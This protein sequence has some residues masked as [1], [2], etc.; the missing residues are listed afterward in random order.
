MN[1]ATDA[2]EPEPIVLVFSDGRRYT[3]KPE[4]TR[5]IWKEVNLGHYSGP[6]EYINRAFEAFFAIPPDPAT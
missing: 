4:I 5:H 3:L 2:S 6:E 1:G